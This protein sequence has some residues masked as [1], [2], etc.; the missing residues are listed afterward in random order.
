MKSAELKALQAPLKERY[1]AA[2]EAALITLRAHGKLGDQG[3]TCKVE[4]GRALVE[5][6][7]A[8]P[9][10]FLSA[11]CMSQLVVASFL[12]LVMKLLNAAPASFLAAA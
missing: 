7:R 12:H 3:V 1:R 6:G 2:P 4:T 10:S 11:A 8:A 5:A 9:A